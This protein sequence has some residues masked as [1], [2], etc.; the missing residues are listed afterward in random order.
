MR[1]VRHTKNA[2]RLECDREYR[3]EVAQCR[4]ISRP[5]QA[6]TA[7]Y[8]TGAARAPNGH[9]QCLGMGRSEA[10]EVSD[11]KHAKRLERD[12][13]YRREVGWL[14]PHIQADQTRAP[15]GIAPGQLPT[16]GVLSRPASSPSPSLSL[17]HGIACNFLLHSSLGVNQPLILQP[18]ISSTSRCP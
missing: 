3:R 14:S 18:R 9:F 4:L 7:R 8:R 6:R 2:K 16:T 13:E 17:A 1:E 10:G 15:R 11:T 5:T 12:R